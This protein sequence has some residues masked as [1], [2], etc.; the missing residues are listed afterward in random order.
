MAKQVPVSPIAT[1]P[2]APEKPPDPLALLAVAVEKGI[3]ANQIEKLVE[4]QERFERNRAAEVF[5]EALTNFQAECPTVFKSRRADGGDK[6]QFAYASFDDVMRVAKPFLAKYRIAISFT[7][8]VLDREVKVICRIR[9]G[10]H[11]EDKQ[12]AVPIPAGKVN[13]TQL[14][15]QALSYCKRYCLC[16]ALNIIVTDE[17]DDAASMVETISARQ[18]SEMKDLIDR[19]ANTDQAIDMARFLKFMGVTRIED[20]TQANYAKAMDLLSGR[21]EKA[22]VV[23]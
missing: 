8:E 4:L 10:A 7:T 20:T 14:A 16:A 18:F 21:L 13:A 15:G 22:K 5:S 23:Q 3:D 11:Y 19:L 17:D 9:V 6:I 2:H 12:F 1:I